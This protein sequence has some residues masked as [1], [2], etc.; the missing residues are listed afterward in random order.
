MK[1]RNE[2][3]A[4]ILYDFLD[5]SR[6]FKGTVVPKDRSMNVPF[7]TGDKEM[8]AKFVRSGAGRTCESERPQKCGRY[9]RK[10][11]QRN[12]ESW[13]GSSC[14]I[15]EKIRGGKCV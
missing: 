10:Y 5:R 15:H 14:S 7:V 9:A 12:A 8:D 2:E 11:L 4:K 13:C 6:L 1:K 3:K